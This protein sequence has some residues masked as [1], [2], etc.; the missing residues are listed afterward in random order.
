VADTRMNLSRAEAGAARALKV[1]D[2]SARPSERLASRESG[3]P[4]GWIPAVRSKVTLSE[5]AGASGSTDVRFEGFASVTGQFYS[6]WDWYGEYEEQ[7]AVGAFGATLM[8]SDLDVPLVLDH[9]SSRRIARTG[10]QFSPLELSEIAEGDVTGL[11]VVAPQLQMSD[12][13]TAYIVEK[14]RLELIDEMSFRF[15][16]TKGRWSEDF[17]QYTI[18][19]VD[20]HRGDVAIVGYGANP[21]TTGAGL[22][23]QSSL[24]TSARVAL[25]LARA[26]D[27]KYR[28]LLR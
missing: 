24:S 6:M 11:A 14:M 12:T 23:N 1:R 22:R 20:I 10:N 7:V 28:D 21:L 19:E 13:D 2:A 4:R 17:T 9:V 25:E 16:I 18:Q 5:R 27:G 8:Q 15:M 3:A 26:D